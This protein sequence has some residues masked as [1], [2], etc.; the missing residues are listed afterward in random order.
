[1]SHI[2]LLC[3]VLRLWEHAACSSCH[4]EERVCTGMCC[5]RQ[6]STMA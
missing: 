2:L 4:S 6:Y 5:G 1:M 3:T